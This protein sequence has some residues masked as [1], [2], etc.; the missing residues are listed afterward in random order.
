MKIDK[1]TANSLIDQLA[2]VLPLLT[3]GR[4]CGI[5]VIATRECIDGLMQSDRPERNVV[6]ANIAIDGIREEF[7]KSKRWKLCGVVGSLGGF[8]GL[9]AYLLQH[10][11]MLR[12]AMVFDVYWPAAVVV[13]LLAWAAFC[14]VMSVKRGKLSS[15]LGLD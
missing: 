9:M 15:A 12:A 7:Q 11:P 1:P 3:Q 5:R 4:A 14:G 8:W 2:H 10:P 13:G 6:I